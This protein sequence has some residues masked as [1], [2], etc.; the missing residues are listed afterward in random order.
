VLY[1]YNLKA[2]SFQLGFIAL[3]NKLCWYVEIRR[4][5]A[6]PGSAPEWGSGGRRFKYPATPTTE[7]LNF[8]LKGSPKQQPGEPSFI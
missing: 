7:G 1:I 6:Q 2:Q 5:V 3:R 4:G 8:Y